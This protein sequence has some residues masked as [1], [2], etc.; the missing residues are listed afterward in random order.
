MSAIRPPSAATWRIIAVG[1]ATGAIASAGA[2]TVY[3]LLSGNAL[4]AALLTKPT[5]GL[6]AAAGASPSVALRG[7][8]ELLLPGA[9][10]AAGGGVAGAG[11]A[12]QQVRRALDPLRQDMHNLAR[13][14]LRGVGPAG[15]DGT[16]PAGSAMPDAAPAAPRGGEPEAAAMRELER[17]RGIGPRYSALL[18]A[19]GIRSLADLAGADPAQIRQLLGASVAAPMAAPAQW[20]SQ[21]RALSGSGS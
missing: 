4:A 20:I 21:A 15:P 12:K 10:G 13:Q 3:A 17:V 7:L 5:L 11:F 1:A 14:V 19:G 8:L 2:V 18:V 16:A 9:V 6:P